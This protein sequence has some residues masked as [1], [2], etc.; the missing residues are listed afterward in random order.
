MKD[1]IRPSK[2]TMLFYLLPGI[3]LYLFVF[4]LPALMAIGLSLFKF[5]SIKNFTFI[6]LKNYMLLTRDTNVWL[7]LKNNLFLVAVS[8]VGQIGIAFLL[9]CLMTS[10]SAGLVNAFRTSIYFPVTLS[11]VVIG[12]V[13]KFV[14]DYNYGI[15]AEILRALGQADAIQPWL[16]QS[17]TVMSFVCIPLIWQYVGFH[18]VIIM[19]A[20][21]T[22]D[23]G[24]F[25][26]ADIDGA[27]ALQRARYITFPLIRGTLIT[28]AM[29]CVSANM[30]VFDHIM[31]MTNGGPGYASNVLALYAYNVS[32]KQTNMGYGSTI[33]VL[34]L[35][36]TTILFVLTSRLTSLGNGRAA[37]SLAG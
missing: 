18:L 20:M 23:K 6:G 10:R 8:L 35:V 27:N 5:S 14:F 17:S 30:K 19:S 36:V 28:C 25:E 4:I 13:W 32:F 9:A 7:A 34:I 12:Y 29:L 21:T 3:A 26:M 2:R 24:V 31:A 22:I 33:S 37:G 1:C 15:L 16:A 11:A